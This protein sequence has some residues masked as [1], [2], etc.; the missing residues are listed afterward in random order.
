MFLTCA[1]S[2]SSHTKDLAG[3]TTHASTAAGAGAA[4]SNQAA[5]GSDVSRVS[6]Q[7]A[8]SGLPD[9]VFHMSG[10]VEAGAEAMFCAYAQMP[11][12]RTTA[13]SSAESHYTK[14]SHH[15]L[16]YRTSLTEIP[17][18]EDVSHLCGSPGTT[19]AMIGGPNGLMS[20]ES[21]TGQTGS[22]Y[23]AQV[24]DS[25]RDLPPGVAHVFTP[26]EILIMTAHYLNT[27]EKAI[28][29]TIE[30]RLHQ[31]DPKAVQGEAGTFFLINTQLNIPAH[32]EVTF[33][34]SCPI[35]Q[36]INLGILWSHMHARGYSFR[37]WT[38]DA[39]ATKR[40]GGDIYTQPGPDAWEEP[41]VQNYPADPPIVL[42]AGSNLM[43]SCTYRN[44]S[45]NTYKFGLSADTAEMCLLHG[46]YWPRLDGATERCSNGTSVSEDPTPLEEL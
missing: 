38:D 17:D 12:D 8:S 1:C 4:G 25:R 36:D 34:K 35:T 32:S 2:S 40:L 18:G 5:S 27:T 41:H 11:T 39:E 42:H 26:G 33:T 37:A 14:G 7:P 43:I 20:G 29:S 13:I 19:V 3:A 31:T 10:R 46:M 28:D 9:I 6:R 44:E 23:E 21:G 16:V 24:P 15:F 45:T 22:Y 30:F